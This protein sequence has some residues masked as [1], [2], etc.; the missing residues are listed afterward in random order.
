ME[1]K[2]GW[3]CGVWGVQLLDAPTEVGCPNPLFFFATRKKGGC[4]F[5]MEGRKERGTHLVGYRISQYEEGVG[6][7]N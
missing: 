3:A 7:R 1:G 4:L 5:F 2:E 6:V